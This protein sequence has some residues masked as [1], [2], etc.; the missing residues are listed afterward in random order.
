MR[1]DH[2]GVTETAAFLSGFG[3][4]LTK[5]AGSAVARTARSVRQSAIARTAAVYN[6]SKRTLSQYVQIRRES[7]GLHASVQLQV[8]AVP[9]QAFTP[10]V[11]MDRFRYVDS[12]GRRVDRRLAA[13][14]V[15]RYTQGRALRIPQAFPL[16]QRFGGALGAGD[17]VRRRTGAARGKLTVL[18]YY[19]FPKRFL[20]ELLPALRA[21]AAESLGVD[22]RAAV[23]RYTSRGRR[24][25][26]RN[27]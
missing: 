18:R 27:D 1:V 6:L 23:R 24:E 4:E 10:K 25:L 12:R 17:Q 20:D 26:R 7:T 13:V 22:M 14:Y 11:Q 8:R 9:I 2:G 19:T 5:A 21:E 15:K 16:R 3:P